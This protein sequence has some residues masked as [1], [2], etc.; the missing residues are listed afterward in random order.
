MTM[1]ATA[2][3]GLDGGQITL[4]NEDLDEG[5]ER[6]QATYGANYARLVEI[7]RTYDPGNLFRSNR[8]I[9]A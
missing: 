9:V 3:T 7:K 6:V 1:T 5:D 2:L 4:T 8:N